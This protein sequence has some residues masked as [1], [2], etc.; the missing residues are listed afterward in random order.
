MSYCR[1]AS[2]PEIVQNFAEY[3]TIFLRRWVV[4]KDPL[5]MQLGK[6]APITI[7]KVS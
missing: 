7:A 4:L 3:V 1:K 2:V 6:V 5:R